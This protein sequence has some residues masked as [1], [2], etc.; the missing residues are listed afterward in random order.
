MRRQFT[1]KGGYY[2]KRQTRRLT[3]RYKGKYGFRRKGTRIK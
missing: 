3:M 2:T 1:Y